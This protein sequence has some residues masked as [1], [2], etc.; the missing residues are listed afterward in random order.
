MIK[1]F[2]AGFAIGYVFGA[3]AGEKRYQEIVNLTE[4]LIRLPLV[5]RLAEDGRE[6]AT[7]QSRRFVG[8]LR[9][10]SRVI[11]ELGADEDEEEDDDDAYDDEEGAY[12]EEEEIHA[13]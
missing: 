11:D 8:N 7:Q 13:R 1:R 4:Q 6:L 5:Q 9:E 10:R 3:R 2:G 12:E